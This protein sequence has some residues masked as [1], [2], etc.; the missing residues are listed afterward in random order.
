MA[1]PSRVGEEGERARARVDG[2]VM[3]IDKVAVETSRG[4]PR[5][6]VVARR[7]V[8][9]QA[10]SSRGPAQAR[11]VTRCFSRGIGDRFI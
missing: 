10:N 8:R 3:M 4:G 7:S 5:R 6:H 2:D 9:D 11:N 1:A